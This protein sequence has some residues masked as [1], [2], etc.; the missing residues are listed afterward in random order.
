METEINLADSVTNFHRS[1][2]QKHEEA[3]KECDRLI[4]RFK[5]IADKDKRRFMLLKQLSIS[6]TLTV[7]LL[8]ALAASK[9]LGDW[10]WIVPATSGLAALSTT[11]LS[12]ATSQKTWIN[13]RNI[14]QKL[15]VEKF[16]Y[17]QASGRYLQ[18]SEE[19]KICHFSNQVMEI[20]SE[21]HENWGQSVSDRKK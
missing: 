19:E 3:L 1:L 13:S 18:M 14:Q 4:D 2:H 21:G 15:Q 8:S 6:L 5:Y 16:L 7:T 20:W 11:L 12:Q 10:E 9:K 17:F